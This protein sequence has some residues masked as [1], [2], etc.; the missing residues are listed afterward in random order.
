VEESSRHDPNWSESVAARSASFVEDMKNKLGL[1]IQHRKV[2]DEG[3]HSI[4]ALFFVSFVTFGEFPIDRF[5]VRF[6]L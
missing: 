6:H 4:F 5:L 3:D 2:R 1:R